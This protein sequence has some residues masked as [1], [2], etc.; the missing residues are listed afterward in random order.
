MM[1]HATMKNSFRIFSLKN[2]GQGLI[3]ISLRSQFKQLDQTA[4]NQSS[5]HIGQLAIK[6]RKRK[7]S[8]AEKKLLSVSWR[9]MS[10]LMLTFSN[11]PNNSKRNLVSGFRLIWL[12]FCVS[13]GFTSY[14]TRKFVSNQ[15]KTRKQT[16]KNG[17]ERK[18]GCQ[19]SVVGRIWV[20]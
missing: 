8:K 17:M 16:I 11:F 18:S 12:H 13:H 5:D 2:I 4:A 15:A 1:Q 7:L 20:W 3:G 10:M 14:L 6:L 19:K 9:L